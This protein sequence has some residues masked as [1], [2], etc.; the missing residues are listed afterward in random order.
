MEVR[1]ARTVHEQRAALEVNVAAWCAAYDDIL[2]AAVL[3]D[4]SAPSVAEIR[5]RDR[6]ELDDDYPGEMLVAVDDGDDAGGHAGDGAADGGVDGVLGFATVEWSGTEAFVPEGAAELR[7]I[8]VDPPLWGDGVGTALLETAVDRVEDRFDSLA[9]Q[10][11][12]ANDPARSFYESRGFDH[13]GGHEFEI[14]GEAYPT[15]VYERS[16]DGVA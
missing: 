5:E 8:Y 9:L 2:P 15:A 7:A 1:P 11:F 6:T 16:L 13:V 12:E 10:V 14:G 3:D 4:L